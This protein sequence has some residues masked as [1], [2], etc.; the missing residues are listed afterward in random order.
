MTT[1]TLVKSVTHFDA[2]QET[3][4]NKYG[5]YQ[6]KDKEKTAQLEHQYIDYYFNNKITLDDLFQPNLCHESNEPTPLKDLIESLA[7]AFYRNKKNNSRITL[8]DFISAGY[9]KA[10]QTIMQYN[11]QNKYWL[12]HHLKKNIRC[13]YIDVLRNEGLTNDRKTHK[14]TAYHKASDL[15]LQEEDIF[16]LEDEVILRDTLQQAISMFTEDELQVYNL[17]L[18]ADNVEK[19]TLDDICLKLNFKYRQQ[20]K[21]LLDNVKMKLKDV[22]T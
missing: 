8:E 5:L 9:E 21:R 10:W 11:Y 4:N 12:Y 16:N 18:D 17:F 13:A 14:H 20:A 22:L 15:T 19:V 1:T 2:V 7:H 3:Y 6:F